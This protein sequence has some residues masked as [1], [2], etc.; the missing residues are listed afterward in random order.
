MTTVCPN[1]FASPPAG[2]LK[3]TLWRRASGGVRHMKHSTSGTARAPAFALPNATQDVPLVIA[4]HDVAAS[5]R[6]QTLES[7]PAMA[8]MPP[9]IAAESDQLSAVAPSDNGPEAYGFLAGEE[10]CR[11]DALKV[12]S[13]L[14]PRRHAPA[15]LSSNEHPPGEHARNDGRLVNHG[16]F[17][18]H[19]RTM[20]L[21]TVSVLKSRLGRRP[22]SR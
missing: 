13:L 14:A 18:R 15:G 2:E 12:A 19:V 9:P 20:V 4:R 10:T 8:D 16:T 6:V 11:P 5:S 7:R 17:L 3:T 1:R 22:A 21:H